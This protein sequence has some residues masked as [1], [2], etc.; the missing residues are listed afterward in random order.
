[1]M[2]QS[3]P[4]ENGDRLTRFQFEQRYHAMPHNNRK[5][6]LI[7]GVVY[8]MA[9]P[10]RYDA[11]AKP[12]ALIMAWLSAY[13]VATRGVELADNAT[14]QFVVFVVVVFVVVVFVVVALAT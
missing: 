3:P 9:S 5:A 8:Y 4:L 6:E 2:L 1:M 14:V 11:H 13:W 7:E 12:H 10:L